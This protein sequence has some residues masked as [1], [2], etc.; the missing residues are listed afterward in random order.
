MNKK[1]KNNFMIK[2]VFLTMYS[3]HSIDIYNYASIILIQCR[4]NK[5]I[6]LDIETKLLYIIMNL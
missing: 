3:F 1:L 6:L 5:Q 4:C 2:N